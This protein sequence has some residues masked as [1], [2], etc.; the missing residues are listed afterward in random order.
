M[1]RVACVQIDVEI[2]KIDSN[3]N[4]IV[5]RIQVAAE[6]GARLAVFPEC[7]LTGYCYESLDEARPFAEM[8][9]GPSSEEIA[10]V[11]RKTGIYAVVGFIEKDGN[12]LFNSAMLV[13]PE[14][15]IGSYRKVHLPFLGVDRFVTPGDRPFKVFDLPI[16][17][18]GI[19]I[20]YDASF[21]EAARALKLLGAEL[22]VLPTNWPPGAR[23]TA[24]FVLN[25]RAQENHVNFLA[26]NRVGVERGWQFIG[27]SKVVDFN[28]DT[29]AEGDNEKEDVLYVDLDLGEA[30][31][32]KIV[33]QPGEYEI[34]RIADRRP[35]FYDVITRGKPASSRS[36]G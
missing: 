31:N 19:L 2:E 27:R 28:G 25:T 17:R 11:C 3:R 18:I 34:D 26:V 8:L 23:R 1:L 30:N 32:N 24:E 13:G 10:G 16:G 5:R 14:G 7:A 12:A 36:T 4:K 35:E 29:I 9:N 33:N 6:S 22:I 21:P 15:P 20:C